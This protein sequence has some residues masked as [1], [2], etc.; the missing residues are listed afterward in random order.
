MVLK[1]EP[2]RRGD[3]GEQLLRAA[4]EVFSRKGYN[5]VTVAD[6][7]A[8]AGLAKGTLYLYFQSK[9][10]L[11][12]EVIR[13]AIQ[14]LRHA[15]G[16]AV[17]DVDDPL[18]RVKVSVPF[19]FKFCHQEAGLYLAIFQQSSFLQSERHEEYKALY[20]PLA[21]DFQMT[22]EEGVRRGVFR[23]GNPYL[24]SHGVHGFLASLI[25]QW[26]LL[27]KE[28]GAPP[29]YLEEM[30]E[31]VSRFFYY[32][33][34]GESFPELGELSEGL[35]AQY[36][37]QLEEIHEWQRELVRLEKILRSYI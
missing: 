5:E 8:E 19:I 37:H 29:G 7:T 26:L 2:G 31:T 30:S 10:E 9:E 24:L 32:G 6:I 34:V 14:R 23:A 18:E 11:F 35:R 21:R 13:D 33:L 17:G 20:E 25:Y 1:R 15:L 12:L 3:R 22:I 27:E 16:E 4:R 36:R 28:G